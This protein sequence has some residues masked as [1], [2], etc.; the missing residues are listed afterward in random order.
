MNWRV[1]LIDDVVR[2]G[3]VTGHG[4]VPVLV[5]PGRGDSLELRDPVGERLARS[6]GE[7]VMVEL[8]GQGASGRLGR[9]RDAV[10]VDGFERHLDDVRAVLDRFDDPVHLVAHSMGG[11]LAAHLLARHPER[12]ASA[13]ISS[14]MW[15]FRQPLVLACALAGAAVS[16]GRAREYAAGEGPFDPVTCVTMRTGQTGPTVSG[17][18]EAFIATHREVVRGGSTW[19][20]VAAAARSMAALDTAPLESFAGPVAVASLDRDRTVSLRAHHR[21]AARFPRG[22]VVELAGGHDPFFTESAEPW[23]STIEALLRGAPPWRP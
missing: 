15:R 6:A 2:V 9:D 19:G 13:A 11:L 23:W 21:V 17:E 8:R 7:V 16:F 10:H 4:S 22:R 18:L 5:V 3:T 14:P 20:W 1:E 12:F